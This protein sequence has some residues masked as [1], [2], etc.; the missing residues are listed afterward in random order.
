MIKKTK[1]SLLL[2]FLINLHFKERLVMLLI[3][4]FQDFV[5]I[6]INKIIS[7]SAAMALDAYSF[8]ELFLYKICNLLA[9]NKDETK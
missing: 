9:N 3:V 2:L 5:L 4:L 1:N 8:T 7:T 6:L